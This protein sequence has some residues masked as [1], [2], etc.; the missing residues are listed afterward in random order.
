MM[1]RCP[2]Y[3]QV[4]TEGVVTKDTLYMTYHGEPLGSS[5]IL[6]SNTTS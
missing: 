3:V 6:L 5:G 1:A 2:F 4:D